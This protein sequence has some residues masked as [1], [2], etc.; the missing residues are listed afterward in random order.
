MRF[1]GLPI[2]AGTTLNPVMAKLRTIVPFAAVAFAMLA[3]AAFADNAIVEENRKPGTPGWADGPIG[4]NFID[5][6]VSSTSVAAGESLNVYVNVVAAPQYRIDVYRLGWYQGTGARKVLAAGPLAATRQPNCSIDTTTRMVSCANWSPTYSFAIPADW[7]TGA[8]WVKF[9]EVGAQG[10]GRQTATAFVVRDDRDNAAHLLQLPFNTYQTYN[11]WGGHSTYRGPDLAFATRSYKVSHDRPYDRG[12]PNLYLFSYPMIRWV[13]RNGFSVSYSASVDTHVAADAMRRR[14]SWLSLGHDEYWTLE[15]RNN[16]TAALQAGVHLAFL[17]GNALYRQVRFEHS[18]VGGNRVIVCYLDKQLDP[19]FT[20]Q[21][22]TPVDPSRVTIEFRNLPSPKPENALVGIMYH[23]GYHTDPRSP[24]SWVATNTTHWAFQGTTLRDGDR[25]PGV[26]GHEFDAVTANGLTP[27]GL[28]TLASSPTC[29]DNGSCT[30]IANTS[31]YKT[32]SGG[33]VFASGTM[34]WVNALDRFAALCTACPPP[35]ERFERVTY[36]IL[37]AFEGEQRHTADAVS[38]YASSGMAATV[39]ANY[40][41]PLSYANLE[42]MYLMVNDSATLAGGCAVAYQRS[43]NALYL[44]DDGGR[45]QLG[46]ITPGR[47]GTLQN[48]QCTLDGAESAAMGEGLDLR[49]RVAL[50]FRSAFQGAHVV[51]SRAT[52]R[53]QQTTGWQPRGY[54]NVAAGASPTLL[55]PRRGI[56]RQQRFTA[57]FLDASTSDGIAFAYLHINAEASVEGGCS[58]AV[59]RSSK[60]LYLLDDSGAVM[61]GPVAGGAAEIAQ[62]SQ[63]ILN[64]LESAVSADGGSLTVDAAIIF[65]PL[66][67]GERVV[68]GQIAD[69]R[70]NLGARL[71]LGSWV[72]TAAPDVPFAVSVVPT[73]GAGM[74]AVFGAFF[75][76]PQGLSGFR[77]LYFRVS[78]GGGSAPACHATYHPATDSLW[79]VNDDNTGV[80]GRVTPGQSGAVENSQCVLTGTGTSVSGSGVAFILKLSITFKSA[81]AGNR[82]IYIQASDIAGANTD[83]QQVGAWS[84]AAPQGSQQ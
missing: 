5:G 69:S 2:F 73:R 3:G 25:I 76:H 46:P 33:W 26:V 65:K 56:G 8:Y 47:S 43:G 9:T 44:V 11:Q 80:A 68:Y 16:V 71:P 13:E 41:D 66:F 64:G 31:I 50:T 23:D 60:R 6:F 24:S 51:F 4:T 57:T 45:T 78:S 40:S 22:G 53:A 12:R 28:E 21:G 79:L 54:F 34:Q 48:S 10:D 67:R 38:P 20:G 59:E 70:G 77:Q 75:W 15:M 39:T 37:K 42:W 82:D 74:R 55:V 27:D 18:P 83:W 81:F 19:F 58:V 35:D 17:S 29:M 30:T 84:V 62:N 63:C 14:R 52:D 7:L 32:R 49:L 61:V 36:N 1:D 72:V